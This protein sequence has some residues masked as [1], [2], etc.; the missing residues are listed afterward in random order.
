MSY[1]SLMVHFDASPGA[2]ARLRLAVGLADR[3]N[4]GLIGIVGPPYLPA[5]ANGIADALVELEKDF[6]ARTRQ[7]KHVE[8]RGRLVWSS[9]LIPQEARAADLVIIGPAPRPRDF[10][11]SQD[12]GTIVLGTGRPVLFVPEQTDLLDAH[13]IV[14][15]WKDTREARRAVCDAL[16]FLRNA[17][18]VAIVEVNEQDGQ[19]RIAADD[20]A[21]YLI[22]HG[23]V[24]GEKAYL[25]AKGPIAN[26]IVRFARDEKADLIVTGGYGHSRLGEWMFGGVT[27]DLLAGSA[28]CCLFS[29]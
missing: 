19:A 27:R 15:A 7:I 24:V 2:Q 17:E 29:N 8:W 5:S 3:F 11:D 12:P 1:Q 23:V 21:E 13:R 20:V 9:V 14:V 26:E 18:T 22:R 25:T 4:G 6:R 16:P 10:A 28:V